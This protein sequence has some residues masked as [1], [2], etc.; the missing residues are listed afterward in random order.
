MDEEDDDMDGADV[1]MAATLD[2][3]VKLQ[4][5]DEMKCRLKEMEEEVAA[6]RDT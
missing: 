3:T 6:L 2:N 5:L 1:G 4:K